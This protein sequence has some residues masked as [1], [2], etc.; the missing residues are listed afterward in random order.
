MAH[1]HVHGHHCECSQETKTDD[2]AVLYNL[3]SRIDLHNLECLNESIENS[4]KSVFRP[5]DER[6]DSDRVILTFSPI[7]KLSLK[8]CFPLVC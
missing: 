7:Y 8:C 1:N 3:Y 4:G 5:W 6:L 2:L